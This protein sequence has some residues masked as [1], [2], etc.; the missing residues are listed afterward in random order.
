MLNNFNY[1]IILASQSPRR[2]QLLKE[3]GIDFE[4]RIKDVNEDFPHKLRREEIPLHLCEKKSDAFAEELK[5]GELLIT[6]DTIVWAQNEVL[7][8]PKDHEDAVKMLSMLSGKMHEVLTGVCLRSA[9]KK[10]SFYVST[11]VYFKQLEQEEIEYYVTNYKPFD[12]AGAYGV[13]EWIGYIGIE[14]IHGS[15]YNV[16]GLPVKELYDALKVF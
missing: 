6:A 8:K 2:Q 1:T 10:H 13:Q 12:K 9:D 16:M 5:D 11:D 3:L 4:T 7:N 14:K 15:Y